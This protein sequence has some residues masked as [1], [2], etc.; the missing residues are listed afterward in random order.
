MT[1]A[2]KFHDIDDIIKEF[3]KDPKKRAAFEKAKAKLENM[4]QHEKIALI[5]SMFVSVDQAAEIGRG[6]G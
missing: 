5:K 6:M 1:D 4:S 2:D 3:C